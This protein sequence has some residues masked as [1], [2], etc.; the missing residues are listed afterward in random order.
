MIAATHV[1]VVVIFATVT[2]AVYVA[3]AVFVT[4]VADVHNTFSLASVR[5]VRFNI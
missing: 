2:A 5:D 4:A 1:I 3:I